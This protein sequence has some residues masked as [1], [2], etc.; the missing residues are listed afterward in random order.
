M[1]N[2]LL[3][4]PILTLIGGIILRIINR[5]TIS[6][7]LKMNIGIDP[8]LFYVDL[9]FSI[10]IFIVIGIILKKTCDKKTIFKSATLLVG[11]SFFL[12]ALSEVINYIGIYAIKFF[13]ILHLWLY[14]PTEIFNVITSILIKVT[15]TESMAL[16]YVFIIIEK[17]APYLF[18]LFVK[19]RKNT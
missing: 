2:K 11:Y 12:F 1:D 3:K 5:I 16:I 4:L 15:S 14:L 19:E 8:G 18:L 17:F 9:I 13:S 10:I 7:L 6:I